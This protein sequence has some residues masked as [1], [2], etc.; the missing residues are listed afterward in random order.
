VG[1]AVITDGFIA[2]DELDER[3]SIGEDQWSRDRSS[4]PGQN[5]LL[6]KDI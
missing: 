3:T 5:G 2:A 1:G 6:A 4:Q